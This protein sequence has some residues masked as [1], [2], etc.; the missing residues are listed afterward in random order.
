MLL[1]KC[2]CPWHM[3]ALYS[4]SIGMQVR[5]DNIQKETELKVQ[6]SLKSFDLKEMINFSIMFWWAICCLYTFLYCNFHLSLILIFLFFSYALGLFQGIQTL[7]N[8]IIPIPCVS[9]DI[10]TIQTSRE[11][12]KEFFCL[13]NGDW[14]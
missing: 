1:T 4:E 11:K 7:D 2:D 3:Y 9:T 6:K 13:F 10:E 8:K 12:S 14:E 5:E